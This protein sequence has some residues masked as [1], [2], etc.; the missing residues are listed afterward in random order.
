MKTHTNYWLVLCAMLATP[1]VWSQVVE[2]SIATWKNN[3]KGA[4]SI[5]HDD[6]GL[7]G[8]DG[9]WQYADTIASNRG[10][11]FVFGVYTEL[12]ETRS[13]R[14]NG[15]SSLYSFAKNVMM[16]KHGHEI[17][18]HS[19]THACAAERGWSPCTFGPGE[20][21]WGEAPLGSDLDLEINTAHNSIVNGTGFTPRYYVYPYD[22]FT[23]ATNK[24][25]EE[26]GYIGSR[27]GW[28]SLAN[29]DKGQG[30]HREGYEQSDLPNFFPNSSGFFRNGVEVFNDNDA[31]LNSQNQIKELNNEIDNIITNNLYGNREF[32]NV[33]N[34][35]WGHVKVDA[36]RAHMNYL[37]EK[38]E[39]R[40]LW[41]GTVSEIF[42]Y[43][44]QKINYTPNAQY[45]SSTQQIVVSWSQPN[46]NVANYLSPL[47]IKSPITLNVDI[48]KISDRS[49]LTISQNGNTIT[50]FRI[51]GNTLI[52]NVYPH[53]G[54]ITISNTGCSKVC[55]LKH[56]SN[57]TAKLN[58][59][60]TFSVDI[61]S[62]QSLNYQWYFNGNIINGATNSS[63]TISQV[64]LTDLGNYYVVASNNLGTVTSINASL[65][66]SERIPY[67]GTSMIV[68]STTSTTIEAED[69]D[70]GGQFLSYY[71]NVGGNKGNVYRTDDVDIYNG[72]SKYYLE[73]HKDEWT[74]Y[75]IEVEKSGIYSFDINAEFLE[76]STRLILEYNDQILTDT[77]TVENATTNSV[78]IPIFILTSSTGVFKITVVRGKAKIDNFTFKYEG[79]AVKADFSASK[80]EA[81]INTEVIFTDKSLGNDEI[82]N[83]EWNFGE[84]AV[85]KIIT[86]KGPHTV[87]YTTTGQ[88]TVSLIINGKVSNIKQNYITVSS[89]DKLPCSFKTDFNQNSKLEFVDV[90][91]TNN[92][93]T[94]EMTAET[95]KITPKNSGKWDNF[96][97]HFNDGISSRNADYSLSVN[98]PLVTIRAKSSYYVQLRTDMVDSRG[99]YT[100]NV[101]NQRNVITLINE[102][103]T[104]TIDYS[105][106]FYNYYG[107]D[108]KG[109]GVMDSANIRGLAFFL[110]PG[111]GGFDG[112]IEIDYIQVGDGECNLIPDF[113]SSATGVCKNGKITFEDASLGDPSSYSWNF[114]EGAFPETSTEKGSHTVS[115]S[116]LGEKTVT[117]T[118][119]G[120]KSIEKTIIVTNELNLSIGE[121]QKVC[122]DISEISLIAET[123]GNV[124]WSTNGTGDFVGTGK[125]VTYLPTNDDKSKDL[126]ISAL[127][128]ADGCSTNQSKE[129]FVQFEVCTNIDSKNGRHQIKLYPNPTED[130]INIEMDTEI[131]AQITIFDVLGNVV[132]DNP[133]AFGTLSVDTETLA[134]GIY[135]VKFISNHQLHTLRF[136]KK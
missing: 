27:T 93:F 32:H 74:S 53:E 122:N 125:T 102:Y 131:S 88:K 19:Y 13:V 113:T 109:C 50:D 41:V 52:T 73:K 17:A 121:D 97:Y 134:S 56:P 18:N 35:G 123:N 51:D 9:I 66:L 108:G 40:E 3:A 136:I 8:A 114:G 60:A 110:N 34:S 95:W 2:S 75:S 65:K 31:K 111:Q 20:S 6:Y 64:K 22:V 127:A 115:Y 130:Q 46:F 99:D 58:Q 112:T 117:L 103:K 68:K 15:Y 54:D 96:T 124:T 49:E 107:C 132:Y 89:N 47:Q 67:F 28:S 4:Y 43:Q 81:I 44:I 61:Q 119:N 24:R 98:K 105:E 106:Q 33:G 70:H 90:D 104:F 36:Y 55:L 83:Y 77:I 26:L 23:N 29:D 30:Y 72:M 118:I 129:I 87:T 5:V 1:S 80:Q 38:V 69:Y 84:G 71:D 63:Y 48:T 45:S 10:I 25:L 12:C 85:P 78:S 21:G 37:K 82:T 100:D 128:S 133:D 39:A 14:P 86:G 42:T 101:L 92:P 16:A 120:N 59:N 7:S 11:K 76:D 62:T 79:A 91:I 135:T 57:Q 116:S 94:H 126:K